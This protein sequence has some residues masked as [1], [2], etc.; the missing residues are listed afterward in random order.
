MS[1]IW[2]FPG[3]GSDWSCSCQPTPQLQQHQI[4]ATSVIYTT[5]HGNAGSWANWA[6][7]GTEPTSSWVL[8]CYCYAT[9]GTPTL[10]FFFF[11]FLGPHPW[12]TD[13]PRLGTKS[14]LQLL[15]YA[16]AMWD[17]SCIGDLHHSSQQ[18]W[19]LTH[20]ARSGIKPESSWILV[21][22]ISTA[23]QQKLQQFLKN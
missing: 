13:G 2:K 15:A 9:M 18:C 4:R 6:R 21:R 19:I 5:A 3:E 10:T 16:T 11:C 14:E 1:S 20:L 23:P 12:H 22:F 17:P 7:P 8:V